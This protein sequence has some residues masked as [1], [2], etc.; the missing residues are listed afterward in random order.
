M[1]LSSEFTSPTNDQRRRRNRNRYSGAVI[2]GPLHREKSILY[3]EIDSEAARRARRSLDVCGHYGRPDIFS[4]AVNRKPLY[5][6]EF[7]D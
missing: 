6:V 1:A 5:P 4:L 7:S 2:A 3:G